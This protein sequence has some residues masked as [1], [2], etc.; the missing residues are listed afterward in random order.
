MTKQFERPIAALIMFTKLPLWR[1]FPNISGESYSHA[2]TWWPFCGWITGS[3]CGALY[4][5]FSVFLTPLPSA[6][7]AIGARMMISGAYHEDGLADFF[8]GF[9]GGTSKEKILSI[10]KDSH[11][12]TYGVIALIMTTL[13]MISLLSSLTPLYG[14][15]MIISADSWSKFCAGRILSF[16]PYARENN[17]SKNMAAY[18]KPDIK[19][20]CI[21]LIC[22]ILPMSII[23]CIYPMLAIC[24]SAGVTASFLITF[25]LIHI[26]KKRIGGYTGDCCGATYIITELTFCL[27]FIISYFSTI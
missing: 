27:F 24:L 16:L 17:S 5:L 15:L 13:L 18:P 4:I 2:V 19:A 14:A 20:F 8:D 11:I 6:I 23:L 9:G 22:G 25:F 21:A 7:L 10:M 26:M 3:I 12:G 1:I